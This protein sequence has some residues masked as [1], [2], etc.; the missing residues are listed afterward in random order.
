MWAYW[1]EIWTITD[2]VRQNWPDI[3]FSMFYTSAVI[4]PV[5]ETGG[6]NGWKSDS[7]RG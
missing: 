6:L 1:H 5:R 2:V 7:A 4:R 3:F